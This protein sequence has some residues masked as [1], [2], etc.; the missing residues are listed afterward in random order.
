MKN[1]NYL[2]SKLLILLACVVCLSC[3]KD[4]EPQPDPDPVPDEEFYYKLHRVEN[5]AV[6]TDDDNPTEAKSAIYLS[7]TTGQE[8]PSAQAK[9]MRWDLSF[10]GLYNSFLG[11]NNGTNA[12]NFGYGGAGK[13]GILI[14]EKPFDEVIEVPDDAQFKPGSG[15]IGTDDAGAFGE[16]TGWYLYDFGGTILGNG[17][18]EKT[19][20]A[21]A[22]GSPLTTNDDKVIPARTV[23]VKTPRGDIAKI[24]MISCYEDAYTPDEWFKDTPHMFF[25]FEY[26]VIPAGSKQFE[27]KP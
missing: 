1:Y 7:L 3:S 2:P 27:I 22:L 25:T 21:Y 8:I 11:G 6:E 9:T 19:H 24:K 10:S 26:V 18:T 14:L 15:I 4:D 12:T 16:G 20:V 23:I 17:T 13:G 5:L